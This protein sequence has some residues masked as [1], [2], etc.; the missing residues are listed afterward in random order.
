MERK[1]ITG[2]QVHVHEAAP[3]DRVF[4]VP[5]QGPCPKCGLW[6]CPD[7]PRGPQP[8]PVQLRVGP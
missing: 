4:L 6:G 8:V 1:V 3:R 5:P 2:I 7:D